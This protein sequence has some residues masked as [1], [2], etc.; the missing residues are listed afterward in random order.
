M[1]EERDFCAWCCLHSEWNARGVVES[2]AVIDMDAILEVVAVRI[3]CRVEMEL[4][5][6][7]KIFDQREINVKPM[8]MA[9]SDI[10]IAKFF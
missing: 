10:S 2:W 4:C 7:D 6:I 9:S 3:V 1:V 5:A 8:S